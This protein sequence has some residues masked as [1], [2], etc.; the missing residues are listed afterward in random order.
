MSRAARGAETGRLAQAERGNRKKN[1]AILGAEHSAILKQN[2]QGSLAES[3]GKDNRRTQKR[4]ITCTPAG[5][6]STASKALSLGASFFSFESVVTTQLLL[7]SFYSPFFFLKSINLFGLSVC[8]FIYL[9]FC[10]QFVSSFLHSSFLFLLS[11]CFFVRLSV[12]TF[13]FVLSIYQFVLLSC[14][15]QFFVVFCRSLF[16]DNGNGYLTP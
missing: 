5:R 4:Q 1:S 3:R 10:W 2:R 9:F 12:C 13:S 11:F 16:L 15:L 8:F 6:D 7:F 14:F